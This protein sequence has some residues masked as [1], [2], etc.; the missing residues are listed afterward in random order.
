MERH[1]FISDDLDDLASLENELQARGILA[2]QI[3]VLSENDGEVERR[4][5]HDV[6]S[7]M[8]RDVVRSWG[9]GAAV[10]LA[11]GLLVLVLAHVSGATQT[12]AGWM[13]FIFL[14][15]VL[16]GFCT[17]E[18]GLFGLRKPNV[19]FR[20]FEEDL[21]AGKHIFFVEVSS[22][23]EAIARDVI[24]QHPKLLAVGSAKSTPEWFISCQQKWRTFVDVMP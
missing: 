16:A 2:S 8:K 20:R 22:E 21:K 17:W 3:H 5:L 10:G 1:Y 15:L 6:N 18:A 23:Q 13:P 19:H 9:V 4:H 12:V 7:L 14:A 24:D 11:I